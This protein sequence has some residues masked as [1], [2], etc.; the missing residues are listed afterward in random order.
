MAMMI[1]G[2]S[3][4]LYGAQA[5]NQTSL[6]SL[7]MLG[8]GNSN[9]TS[10]DSSN[11]GGAAVPSSYS[12]PVDRSGRPLVATMSDMS[13]ASS[14]K[15]KLTI[16]GQIAESLRMQTDCAVQ[17]GRAN[18]IADLSKQTT[19]LMDAATSAVARVATTDGSVANGHS[20][21]AV[22]HYKT[23]ISTMLGRIAS[24]MANLKVLTSKAPHGVASQTN[25]T[26]ATLNTKAKALASQAGLDWAGIKKTTSS[27]TANASSIPRLLD[28]MV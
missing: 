3:Q 12:F 25:A 11:S 21:P 9:S 23:S 4:Y 19:S 22:A 16:A 15:D 14:V 7:S 28:Y 17:T 24:V 8:G 1:G 26:L 20:D 5:K 6:T 27:G 13:A 2:L 10:S 18:R